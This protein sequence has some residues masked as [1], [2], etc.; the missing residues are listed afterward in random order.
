LDN[1]YLS[2][3]FSDFEH[4]GYIEAVRSEDGWSYLEQQFM[5]YWG[6]LP[7]SRYQLWH[8]IAE[9]KAGDWVLV[10]TY[11]EFSIYEILEDQP[12]MVK[13]ISDVEIKN[14]NGEN[15]Q[16]NKEG[17]LINEDGEQIDLGFARR[18]K[19]IFKGISRYDYADSDLTSRL[20]VR[21]TNVNIND[22]ADNVLA[23]LDKV[24]SNNPIRF[25]KELELLEP[26]ICEIIQTKLNPDK[27]EYLVKW[28]FDR[29]GASSVVIPPKNSSE[30]VD[31]EDVDV[32]ATFDLLKTI[33]YVQVKQYRG[34]T[35]IWAAEQISHLKELTDGSDR[36]DDGYTRVYWVLS[37]SETFSQDCIN[38]ARESNV[39]LIDGNSFASML[40]DAGFLGIS[41][42]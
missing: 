15:I 40:I 11:G 36:Q 8:F 34:E 10:P 37:S 27:F 3:G 6:E 12:L 7:R 21:Q 26:K 23:A 32:V 28:Y 30:K 41:D 2:Y 4:E 9:M 5:E 33:Y 24:R 17:Y 22:L 20:K 38:K 14:W 35:N 42:F 25:R 16:R 13:D 39:Q 29:I 31:Y 19:P 18:V 1:N